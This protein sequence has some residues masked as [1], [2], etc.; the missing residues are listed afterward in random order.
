MMGFT[1]EEL[2]KLRRADEEIERSFALTPEDLRRG[3]ELDRA[4][5]LE[6]LPHDERKVAEYKR[7]YYEANREKVAA[8][9]RAYR[10]ANREKVAEYQRAYYEANREKVAEYNRAYYE[11]NREKVAAQ[12]RAYREARRRAKRESVEAATLGA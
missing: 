1:K 12:Q 7:A 5:R 8:R 10:E 11:A 9:Q 3:R 2:E 4:A 6:A